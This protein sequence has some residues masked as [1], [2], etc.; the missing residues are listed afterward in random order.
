MLNLSSPFA[1]FFS[2]DAFLQSILDDCHCALHVLLNIT[3]IARI[4][5][6]PLAQRLVEASGVDDAVGIVKRSDIAEGAPR[7]DEH[8]CF[9]EVIISFDCV[10]CGGFALFNAYT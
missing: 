4:N 2:Y 7:H 9:D 3:S 5:L 10:E 6:N 8:I 1:N